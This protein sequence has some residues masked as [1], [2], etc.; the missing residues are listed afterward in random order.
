MKY[1]KNKLCVKLVF[2]YAVVHF[3]FHEAR[4]YIF[5]VRD[6]ALKDSI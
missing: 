2:P 1:T 3:N 4:V 5:Q 6:S